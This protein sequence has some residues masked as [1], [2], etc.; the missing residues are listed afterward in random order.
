MRCARLARDGHESGPRHPLKR[1]LCFMISS[2]EI[3]RESP[4]STLGMLRGAHPKAFFPISSTVKG[5]PLPG[6]SAIIC[7]FP[8]LVN[9]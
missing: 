3:W 9:R 5:L 4:T 8:Y 2:R 6:T 7:L 1:S